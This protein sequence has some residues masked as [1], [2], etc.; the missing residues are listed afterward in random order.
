M[1]IVDDDESR[2][3][4]LAPFGAT[5]RDTRAALG[6]VA[7]ARRARDAPPP[8]TRDAPVASSRPRASGGRAGPGVSSPVVRLDGRG[9]VLLER[10][11]GRVPSLRALARV[12]PP[13]LLRPGSCPGGTC[14]RR[15]DVRIRLRRR[16][17]VRRRGPLRVL[18]RRGRVPPRRVVEPRQDSTVRARSRLGRR[19]RRHR[20]RLSRFRVPRPLLLRRRAI[21]S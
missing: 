7:S 19:P 4:G 12:Q 9:R 6:A 8:S 5:S 3:L 20:H 11:D 17:R 21:P 15:G 10:R 1:D 16:R 13:R 14:W 18:P 2:V